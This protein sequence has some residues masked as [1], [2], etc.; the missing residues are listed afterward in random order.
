VTPRQRKRAAKFARKRASFRWQVE[1]TQRKRF[2][3]CLGG[4]TMYIE[5]TGTRLEY[6]RRIQ[7]DLAF[8]PDPTYLSGHGLG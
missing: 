2:V 7:V 3:P 5:V 4:E 6:V 1:K 8:E